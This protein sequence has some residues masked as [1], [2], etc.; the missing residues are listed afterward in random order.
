MQLFVIV[1][2]LYV[3]GSY[4]LSTSLVERIQSAV[5]LQIDSFFF[6]KFRANLGYRFRFEVEG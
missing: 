5:T 1:Q 4:S 2:I 3:I 6:K